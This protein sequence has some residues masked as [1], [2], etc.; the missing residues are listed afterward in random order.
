[1]EYSLEGRKY[2][3]SYQQLREGYIKHC[4]MTDEEFMKSLP[5]AIHLAC[6]ICFFKEIPTYICLS[7]IGI[8]HELAHLIH[9]PDYTS[10]PNESIRDLRK[11]FEEQ[12]KLA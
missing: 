12:L 5:S 10:Y 7:D 4:Q 1:M 6:V 9:I 3:I 8:V 11:L 2:E